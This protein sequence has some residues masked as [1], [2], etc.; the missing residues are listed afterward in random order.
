[1]NPR[2]STRDWLETVAKRV[3]NGLFRYVAYRI[4]RRSRVL[5]TKLPIRLR[6]VDV[7]FGSYSASPV[8]VY[9]TSRETRI[10][11]GAYCSIGRGVSLI[12]TGG[13]DPAH[14]TTSPLSQ[15]IERQ[16][17]LSRT[18]DRG[19]VK[20]G[21]DVWIGD[22]VTILGGVTIGDGAVIGTMSLVTS[23]VASYSIH[24]G[25]PSREIS[26][27]F[28]VEVVERLKL[29]RWWALPVSFLR[30]NLELFYD[31]NVLSALDRLE[32]AS[33]RYCNHEQS[34]IRSDSRK[35]G[36]IDTSPGKPPS[37]G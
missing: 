3:D 20:I 34:P 23:D 7:G 13:H 29:L 5:F 28:P 36:D 32:L 35:G 24:G 19:P 16:P 31:S 1:M 17:R 27:R 8:D 21:N 10:E 14:L 11:I 6:Q 12:C 22:R 18:V 33:Q 26:Q 30:E 37:A 25:A 9:H 15:L 4:F 2:P